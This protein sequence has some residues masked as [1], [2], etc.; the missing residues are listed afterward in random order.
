M[1][2][3][4]QTTTSPTP[5][6]VAPE[7]SPV[8][9]K[10][11]CCVPALL[12]CQACLSL[13]PLAYKSPAATGLIGPFLGP[14]FWGV[15]GCATRTPAAGQ[16]TGRLTVVSSGCGDVSECRRGTVDP[17]RSIRGQQHPTRAISSS[18][19]TRAT[20]VV[21]RQTGHRIIIPPC[22]RKIRR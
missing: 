14:P 15:V 8:I 11:A 21:Y 17:L 12:A 13:L 18:E 16:P 7:T 9:C 22:N 20:Y 3:N 4:R 6:A 19:Y 1:W 2:G 5:L 10:S